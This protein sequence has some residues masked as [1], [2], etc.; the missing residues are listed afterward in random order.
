MFPFSLFLSFFPPLLLLFSPKLL[1]P[2][3]WRSSY[4][5]SS[6][7]SLLSSSHCTSPI[8]SYLVAILIFTSAILS[9]RWLYLISSAFLSQPCPFLLVSVASSCLRHCFC[10][11]SW[12]SVRPPDAFP[13]LPLA[14]YHICALIFSQSPISIFTASPSSSVILSRLPWLSLSYVSLCNLILSLLLLHFLS[15]YLYLYLPLSYR[16]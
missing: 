11:T 8:F 5:I 15:S 13:Y 7:L 6:P 1:P 12:P 16:H 10:L 9:L 3:Q 14:S 4:L 2:W